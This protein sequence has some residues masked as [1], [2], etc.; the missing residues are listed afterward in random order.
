[1]SSF[2][3]S[4]ERR[5]KTFPLFS[6]QTFVEFHIH[7]KRKKMKKLLLA[8]L[9]LSS[10]IFASTF[11]IDASHSKV[12]FKVKHMAITNTYGT[13]T[14]YN[15]KIEYDVKSKKLTKL[16]A[17]IN[18]NSINTE[19]VKRDK[20]LRSKE[21]FDTK[22]F[23]TISFNLI[24]TTN[25]EAIGELTIKGITKKITFNY[26]NNGTAIDPW[27][28]LKVGFSL[29][30]KISRKEFGLTFNK[31]LDTGSF[32]VGDKITILIEIEATEVK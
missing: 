4:Q 5:N 10:S 27:R 6:L 19:D 2:T 32:I 14:K 11:E 1:M 18:A 23:P 22:K 29:E 24:S 16:E 20:H 15:A 17:I 31:I 8:V 9:I 30:T 26:E 25:D 28:G 21:F 7:K 13:F 12:A 3:V